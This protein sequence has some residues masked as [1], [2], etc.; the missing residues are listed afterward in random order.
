MPEALLNDTLSA[1]VKPKPAVTH[2]TFDDVDTMRGSIFDGV[3][4]AVAKKYPVE[5]TRYRMEVADLGYGKDKPYSLEDQKKA[6]MTGQTMTRQLSGTW[7]LVDKESGKVVDSKKA[8]IAHVP[9]VTPRGT[10]IY[11]GNEYTISNQMRLKPGVYSRVKDNGMIEAHFNV[12]PGTGPSFRMYMEPDTGIFRLAVGQSTLKMYPILK[13]MGVPDR[14]IEQIWGKELL[15]KN[16]EAA[17]PRAVS[18]AF[19]KLVATRADQPGIDADR[20][21]LAKVAQFT[22]VDN[23]LV[24]GPSR[25]HGNGLYTQQPVPAG[26]RVTP[27]YIRIGMT[28]DTEADFVRSGPALWVNHQP[29]D[30]ANTV[31]AV[32]PDGRMANLIATRD[33]EPWEEITCDYAKNHDTL[34]DW[35]KQLYDMDEME[36]E[37]SIS[38][39]AM[40]KTAAKIPTV[41]VDLDGTLA[42]MYESFD[43]KKIPDPRPGARKAMKKFQD[44]GYRVLIH[45]V[46]GDD[47]LTK[48]WLHKH[49]IPYDYVNE[50]PDQPDTASDKLIADAYVDDRGVQGAQAWHKIEQQV[51]AKLE[52]EAK[53]GFKDQ[54][55]RW[56]K[57]W[58]HGTVRA[59]RQGNDGKPWVYVQVHKGLMDAARDSLAN[60]GVDIEKNPNDPHI[61]LLRSSEAQELIDRHGEEQWKGAAKDG[62]SIRFALRR[63]MSLIPDGWDGVDRVWFI[64]VE[65]P[66]LKKYRRDLGFPELPIGDNGNEHRFHITFAIHRS[67]NEPKRAAYLLSGAGI[68]IVERAFEKAAGATD[69]G[70]E[71][72]QVFDRMELDPDVTK[73][74][75]GEG[76]KNA[77]IPT[78][79]RVSQKL[80]N[81][82]K[83]M[84]D[85][86]DRDSL[87]YQ[88]L[89]GP[90]D[91][92]T[93]RV[94]R[95]AGQTG[96]KLLWRATLRGNLKHVPTGALSGQMFGVLLRSGMGMSLEETN[97]MDI[98]D[99]NLRVI[100]L[101]EGGIP[102]LDSVPEESRN[103]Q[104]SHFAY[105]D[106]IRSPESEKIGVDSRVSHRV[107]KGSDGQFHAPMFNPK[108]GKEEMVSAA[109]AAE[110]VVAFPGELNKKRGKVR[111]M[112]KSRQVQ[113]VDRK[114]VDYE[115]E[116]PNQMFTLSSNLVPLVSGIKGGRLLMGAKYFTQALP[117][118]ER[119]APLVRNLERSGKSF[120]E[121]YGDRVGAIRAQAPGVVTSMNKNGIKVKYADGTTKEHEL[122]RNFPFNRKSLT[123]D[124]EVLIKRN[125][126]LLVTRLDA[127]EFEQGDLTLSIDPETKLSAWMEVTGYTRHECD[128]RLYRV[129]TDSGRAFTITEDHS[130]MVMG[131]EGDLVPAYPSACV[132]GHTRIPVAL[133]RFEGC[134][135]FF[136][137]DKLGTLTGLYLAEGHI[138]QNQPNLIIIAV[139]P[140]ERADEVMR[141][142]RELGC[143]PFRNGGSVC[144]TDADL[145]KFLI[146][147]CGH[148]SHGKFI[149]RQLMNANMSFKQ[150]LLQGYL[151]GD[152]NLWADRNGTVQLTAVTVSKR[153]RDDLVV[154]AGTLGV[155]TT[156]FDVPRDNEAWRDGYGLRFPNK[157]LKRTRWM[158]YEDR[159]RL[160]DALVRENTRASKFDVVPVPREARKA[161]YGE[162]ETVPHFVYKTVNKGY[163]AKHRVRT[164]SGVFGKWGAS[165]VSWDRIKS[166]TEVPSEEYVYDLSVAAS[167]AFAVNGGVV[168]HNT[169][170]HN[171][172]TVKIGDRVRKGQLLATSNYTDDQGALALGTNLRT[173]YVPYKGLNFEDAIVISESAAKRLS[174]EHMYQHTLD[175]EDDTVTGRKQFVSIYPTTFNR[176]QLGA[177]DERG[178]AKVGTTI[179]YGDPVVLSMRKNQPSAVHRGR[180]PMYTDTSITWDHESPGM[181][182]GVDETDDGGFNVT[183]KAYMPAQEGDKL[184]GR[185]GDKG[186]ISKVVPDDQMMHDRDGK[187]YEILLN[188]LGIITRGNPSQVYET[189]LGKVARKR[190]KPIS[191]P[192][193]M[194]ESMVDYVRKELSRERMKSHEDLYDPTTNRKVPDILTGDR[195]IFKL[196]HTAE[197]KGKGRDVGAYTS[198]GIPAKGGELGSKRVSNMEQN[199]LLSHGATGVLRDAQVVR[200]QRN[201]DFWRAFRMGYTPPSPS[202][203]M[204]YD[205]FLNHLRGA[206][207]NVKKN[208]DRT[209]LLAMTDK[210]VDEMTSGEITEA[211]TVDSDTL[212]EI[213]GGLFDRGLTGGHGGSRWSHIKLAEPMPNPVMEEPIRRMLGLTKVKFEEVLQG[214]EDIGGET[215]TK[216]IGAALKRINLD[217]AIDNAKLIIKDGAKSKRDNAVK[218]LGYYETLKKAGMKPSDLMLSKVPVLP[219]SMRPIT[220]YRSMQLSAD[221]NFLYRDLINA[222]TDLK[223]ISSELGRRHGGRARLRT[224]HA[225]KAVTGLGDPVQAKTQEKR[226]KGLLAH[227]F[228]SSPKF[229]MF[230]RRVLGSPVDVVGRAAITPNPSLSMDQVGIPEDKV[231]TIYRPFVVR[232]LI[233]RGMPAMDAAKAAANRT[234]VAANALQEEISTRPVLINRA[235][236]LHRYGFMAAWPV[237]TKGKTLQVS[238]T[239]VGG[240][241]ADFDGD[242]MNYHVPVTDEAVADAVDK[243]LPSKNLKSARFFKTH[244]VPVN[245]FLMGLYLASTAK[246]DK[247]LRVFRDKKDVLAA[248]QRGDIGLGDRVSIR[249]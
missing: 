29:D 66:D 229:G 166:I 240:F 124:C 45:T 44:K 226:V 248:Y 58:F 209:Q 245:E 16:T 225:F 90:E 183:V 42:E 20:E 177:L 162:L 241:N 181:V 106:P 231:W 160:L 205:K 136:G 110:S 7:R 28:G 35:V 9:Y 234:E 23:D 102:S 50:N 138:P 129:K 168:V 197:S 236:T 199:A 227:V 24:V 12:A 21:G 51:S 212:K 206:G 65:S 196:H 164:G 31:T 184:A 8:V 243:M 133:P 141:L 176:K 143:K 213:D 118:R 37:R 97:P 126:E 62:K 68:G 48:D 173:A 247:P 67:K 91:F 224:Y 202:V 25:V 249:S 84:E 105:L 99:Q 219:P 96:R 87:A 246:S 73:S 36:A 13:A 146:K 122:Y 216:A 76:F 139:A 38:K 69:Q 242:A 109:K 187:P 115:V 113:Y 130:L 232:R 153:L 222:N 128:K 85:T 75:V 10:F 39:I 134:R 111:A 190:G 119:E 182:T 169:F 147:N 63:M 238:P 49:D 47:Q 3:L 204:V 211:K 150:A 185:Y 64:E 230:Q 137:E 159:Q 180:K 108:T 114:D 22:Q 167:E 121:L 59:Q 83:G 56:T 174:S 125:G 165:D 77:G 152:G 172:P 40:S 103:V 15:Q 54:E 98:M 145:S 218:T 223:E 191:V 195:F 116:D 80:L 43:P 189:L 61:T 81:I 46:R 79:L 82:S 26:T 154:L 55:M 18:R 201:D 208:G 120:D 127:Y 112:V 71:L 5:N 179:K 217:E 95:D 14:E 140:E 107:M 60:E 170:I 200:G 32:A 163:V 101:G 161:L 11:R 30:M 131:P 92:F 117:L 233:R 132:V 70:I 215:G 178:V 78:L 237:L 203:P 194:D 142:F 171:T 6:I 193:F 149:G 210:D 221:P 1:P 155:F 27:A 17:D 72:N 2:R 175:K 57:L 89:Y 151:A 41:A 157:E 156:L 33:I 34:T 135:G 94:N 158:F 188:P 93:E 19:A 220:Q 86:D 207:I 198:E 53:I 244:Y 214:K 192:G 74:T 88:K 239:T 104:P 148:L 52:K 186:V 228:G 235:P 4:D 123:G 100:R 144:A